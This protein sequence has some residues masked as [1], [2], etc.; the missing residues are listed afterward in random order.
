MKDIKI[1][2][3]IIKF[4]VRATTKKLFITNLIMYRRSFKLCGRW[5]KIEYPIGFSK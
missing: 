2:K 3:L 5:F 1:G 4:G